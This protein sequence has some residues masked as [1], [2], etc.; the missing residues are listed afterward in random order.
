MTFA[1]A[2]AARWALP[3]RLDILFPGR[4]RAGP[5]Y[6]IIRRERGFS[7]SHAGY[8]AG[9]RELSRSQKSEPGCPGS[10]MRVPRGD[11][12]GVCARAYEAGIRTVS[13]TWITPLD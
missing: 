1:G 7:Y 8:P 12:S 5:R 6:R 2:G 11:D 3:E 4:F 10:P 9:P 13:T